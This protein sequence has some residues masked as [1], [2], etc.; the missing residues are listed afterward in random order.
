MATDSKLELWMYRLLIF[1]FI[2]LIVFI[3]V[4]GTVA[5]C[6][7]GTSTSGILTLLVTSIHHH[8]LPFS[9][10]FQFDSTAIPSRA[11]I[12]PGP[13]LG[14]SIVQSIQ[15]KAPSITSGALSVAS[16][17]PTAVSSAITT[18]GSD[19]GSMIPKSCTIGTKYFCVGY[20]EGNHS[21]SALPLNVSGLISH[22]LPASGNYQITSSLLR[23]DEALEYITPK[24]IQ[25]FLI[26]GIIS[27]LI[28]GIIFLYALW[29]EAG[30][31]LYFWGLPL[32]TLIGVPGTLICFFIFFIPTITLCMFLSKIQHLPFNI[33]AERGDLNGRCLT[34]LYC[35]G[36]LTFPVA[37]LCIS[38]HRARGWGRN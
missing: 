11:V 24:T 27:T 37:C 6:V 25:D 17:T 16:D 38:K 3:T 1:T 23:L 8:Y 26:I 7:Q 28:F 10:E 12:L 29:R 35:A 5:L 31:I 30:S 19:L 2:S 4:Y 32:E 21:Y 14:S 9:N 34:I 15:S 36:F 20:A 33:T 18:T 22:A 13:N